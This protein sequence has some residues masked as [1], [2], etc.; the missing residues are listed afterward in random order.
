MENENQPT[1][2]PP[3]RPLK[4]LLEENDRTTLREAQEAWSEVVNA[5]DS[6]VRQRKPYA[7]YLVGCS[8][9][10]QSVVKELIIREIEKSGYEILPPEDG[11]NPLGIKI[12][13]VLK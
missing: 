9:E 3:L 6:G 5:V 1:F 12:S 13:L 7:Y 11:D 4:E 10:N 2:T 8:Y